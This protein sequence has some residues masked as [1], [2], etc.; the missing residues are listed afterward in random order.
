MRIKYNGPTWNSARPKIKERF[1]E[2]GITTCE[3]RYPGCTH[4]DFRTFAH[5]L[6]RNKIQFREDMEEVVL[7]CQPCHAILDA[8]PQDVTYEIVCYLRE[9]RSIPVKSIFTT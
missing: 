6:R 3:L 1:L 2:A 9:T 4:A 5:S 7:A 8:F